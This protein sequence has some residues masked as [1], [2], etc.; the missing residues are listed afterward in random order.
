MLN[1]G[2]NNMV[3]GLF[4][5]IGAGFISLC[6]IGAALSA[7]TFLVSDGFDGFGLT[8]LLASMLGAFL[9]GFISIK[10]FTPKLLKWLD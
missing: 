2:S 5:R 6:A 3:L 9:F 7:I 1:K 8:L 4:S 10:G